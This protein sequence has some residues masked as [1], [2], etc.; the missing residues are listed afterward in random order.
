MS[1]SFDRMMLQ[2]FWWDAVAL[3]RGRAATDIPSQ[4]DVLVIGS[5]YAGA[6]AALTLAG[7]GARV[8]VV[9]AMRI[10]EGASSRSG[11]QVLA[12]VK[13][14]LDELTAELGHDIAETITT[15]T[16]A[17]FD[18]LE[19]RLGA[20]GGTPKYQRTGVF[21][22][23]HS[24]ASFD[25]MK[26]RAPG[27]RE[28]MIVEPGD[29]RAEVDTA[30]FSG[31]MIRARGG[32]L[33]P[34]LYHQA[35]TDAAIRSGVEFYERARVAV[36]RKA[37]DGFE[38]EVVTRRPDAAATGKRAIRSKTMLLATNGY[39][40]SLVPWLASRT[41]PVP[42]YM[43]ATEPLDGDLARRLIPN[44]RAISD[45]R[46]MLSYFRLCPD[47]QR[48]LF[49][50]RASFMD[51]A[52]A[53]CARLLAQMMYRVFPELSKTRITHAWQGNVAF[54]AD[55]L[56]HFGVGPDGIYYTGPYNGRGVALG[57]YLGHRVALRMLGEA[58]PGESLDKLD[59]RRIHPGY[60][61][62]PW[63]LP[64]VGLWYQ[65]QDARDVWLDRITSRQ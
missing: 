50:G 16:E 30:A 35:L 24:R 57:T 41:V 39:T 45:T 23:A 26:R 55:M 25:G 51:R 59:H 13:R 10:G 14:P 3:D 11:G 62:N 15:E 37:P 32:H 44:R 48:M 8:V 31:G 42:S 36:V 56:P 52:P 20:I 47:G 22:G 7:A 27:L 18:F 29:V 34:A 63:F 28:A 5:G 21:I 38:A 61:G 19:K 60:R 54:A 43:I 58:K 53:T 64:I 12:G 9:D 17:A 4:A 6:S 33:H 46:R 49:G 2:P 1:E 40:S 65:M